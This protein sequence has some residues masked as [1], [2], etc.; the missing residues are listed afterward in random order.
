MFCSESLY[1][2]STLR[3][4]QFFFFFPEENSSFS[5]VGETKKKEILASLV[6]GCKE[7]RSWIAGGMIIRRKK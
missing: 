1:A 6:E 7:A 2:L 4:I 3:A 5:I